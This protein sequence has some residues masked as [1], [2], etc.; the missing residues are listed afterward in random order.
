LDGDSQSLGELSVIAAFRIEEPGTQEIVSVFMES[1]ID[2]FLGI[3]YRRASGDVAESKAQG[4]Q[5]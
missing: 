2:E 3:V 4:Q 1:L 5:E